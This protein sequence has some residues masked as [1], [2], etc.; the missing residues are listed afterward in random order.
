MKNNFIALALHFIIVLIS[1]IALLIFF[2]AIEKGKVN[3]DIFGYLKW[4]FV[5]LILFLYLKIPYFFND[6]KYNHS[7]FSYG[8]LIAVLGLSIW[9]LTIIIYKGS[10]FEVSE[11][12][13]AYWI[14]F[15]T[16]F[17]PFKLIYFICGINVTP[18]TSL[19]TCFIP[20]ILFELSYQLKRIRNDIS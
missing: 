14:I 11:S 6:K 17:S 20:S 16:F 12:D 7:F 9:G 1:L 5:I 10:F 8:L 13:M 19:I 3:I 2:S 15:Y 18:L 4:G